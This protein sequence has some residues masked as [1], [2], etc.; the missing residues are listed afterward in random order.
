M[1]HDLKWKRSDYEKIMQSHS[2][3]CIGIRGIRGG[4]S[5]TPSLT[6]EVVL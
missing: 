3:V 4:D 2:S 6:S 5:A 1:L